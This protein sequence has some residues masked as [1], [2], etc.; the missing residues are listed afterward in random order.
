MKETTG[1]ITER[2]LCHSESARASCGESFPESESCCKI[3]I[4]APDRVLQIRERL[5]GIGASLETVAQCAQQTGDLLGVAL[6]SARG[7]QCIDA[8]T[9]VRDE[10]IAEEQHQAHRES[11]RETDGGRDQLAATL[12]P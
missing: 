8:R 5:A 2:Y 10:P 11:Q 6:Q 12:A 4:E 3:L 7:L 1:S 9:D